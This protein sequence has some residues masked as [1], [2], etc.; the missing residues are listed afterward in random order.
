MHQIRRS[1]FETPVLLLVRH[2]EP[3]LQEDGLVLSKHTF[4]DWTLA[5]ETAMP[6]GNAVAHGILSAAPVV[7]GT[8]ERLDLVSRWQAD[9]VVLEGPLTLFAFIRCRQGD[10]P[11]DPGIEMFGGASNRTS[12]VRSVTPLENG[13]DSGIS[14]FR[15]FLHFYELGLQSQEFSLIELAIYLLRFPHLFLRRTPSVTLRLS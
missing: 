1:R 13:D 12:F 6:I 11:G 4:E 15:P 5:K 9:N 3:I 8:V 14:G 10:H 2:R 7:P